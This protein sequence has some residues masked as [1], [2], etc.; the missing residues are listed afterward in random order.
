MLVLILTPPGGLWAVIQ[1]LVSAEEEL[2]LAWRGCMLSELLLWGK[3]LPGVPAL[4]LVALGMGAGGRCCQGCLL[5]QAAFFYLCPRG[6]V[7]QG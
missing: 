7:S 5:Y 2:L 1:P 3:V 6:F 4:A